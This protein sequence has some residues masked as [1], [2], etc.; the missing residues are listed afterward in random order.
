MKYLVITA[1]LGALLVG[2]VANGAVTKAPTAH[3]APATLKCPA[4]GMAMST[5]KSAATPV[6]VYS[7]KYKTTYYCCS[8]CTTG[9]SAA[10]YL[11]KHHKTEQM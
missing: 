11:K 8:G 4:C 1:A 10:A 7:K 3:H 5:K 2:G 6:P 9:K